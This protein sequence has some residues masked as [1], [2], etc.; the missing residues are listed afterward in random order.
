M[1]GKNS[2]SVTS[3]VSES[4]AYSLPDGGPSPG[5]GI[6]TSV[7]LFKTNAIRI[8]ADNSPSVE[9][10]EYSAS[11]EGIEVEAL[12][13]DKPKQR[14]N[15][16][17]EGTLPFYF[18]RRL[19]L[20]ILAFVL[21]MTSSAVAGF[22][23]LRGKNISSSASVIS[24]GNSAEDAEVSEILNVTNSNN[25][26][27]GGRIPIDAD[28]DAIIDLNDT[29]NT[30]TNALTA[31]PLPAPMPSTAAPTQT[32]TY[33]VTTAF[34]SWDSSEATAIWSDPI[35]PEHNLVVSSSCVES[36]SNALSTA[37]FCFSS[38]RDGDW[39]WVRSSSNSNTTTTTE[40]LATAYD[41]WDYTEETEGELKFLDL[42]KGD[43]TISLVRDSMQPYDE[44]V[45]HE[46]TVP[47]CAAS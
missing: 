36:S 19:L 22:L 1:P 24:S 2:V 34:S 5:N 12:E 32:A 23:V 21:I 42:S 44:I 29:T 47:E 30:N 35:C 4:C 37:S 43:Y 20:L 18:P 33:E 9:G 6:E 41:S 10:T 26:N 11:N 38:K 17:D 28:E 25:D 16:Y 39:Y 8:K 3:S 13:F 7:H 15:D 27:T 40:T 45:S 14:Y 46:F 31:V